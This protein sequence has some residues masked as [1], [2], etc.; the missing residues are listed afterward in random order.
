MSVILRGY[1]EADPVSVRFTPS[2]TYYVD[3]LK[4]A[5]QTD[6]GTF[7][8]PFK[9]LQYAH[10]HIPVDTNNVEQQVEIHIAPGVYTED[11][12]ITKNNLFWTNGF[13][14]RAQ[15]MVSIYGT[16]TYNITTGYSDRFNILSAMRGIKIDNGDSSKIG[17]NITSTKLARYLFYDLNIYSSGGGTCLHNT[18]ENT[19]Y[20]YDCVINIGSS[21]S[22]HDAVL[23][24]HGELNA[25]DSEFYNAGTGHIINILDNANIRTNRCVIETN[26]STGA[27]SSLVNINN[28]GGSSNPSTNSQ[29]A[30]TYFGSSGATGEA[31]TILNNKTEV[32][33]V[34]LMALSS[35]NVQGTYRFSGN[36]VIS[37]F[38]NVSLDGSTATDQT[39]GNPLLGITISAMT[40]TF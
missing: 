26:R 27:T 19:I 40:N 34:V 7:M 31:L 1:R 16:V 32:S 10:D 15:G 8:K 23:F 17:L 29:F 22:T 9:T 24:T 28:L 20:L 5:D 11:L 39:S 35:T 37:T 12:V 6:A 36:G 30:L 38:Q 14:P 2:R 13:S 21:S 4:G 3:S 18:S 25:R 33:Q